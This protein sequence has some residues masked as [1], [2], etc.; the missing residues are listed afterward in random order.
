[1]PCTGIPKAPGSCSSRWAGS[2]SK[3]RAQSLFCCFASR[4]EGSGALR[5]L[6]SSVLPGSDGAFPAQTEKYC[7]GT[8]E[9]STISI[10]PS[11]GLCPSFSSLV[12][13]SQWL[14]CCQQGHCSSRAPHPSAAAGWVPAQAD[15]GLFVP[16]WESTGRELVQ[17]I[18]RCRTVP[19]SEFPG[20]A[21]SLQLNPTVMPRLRPW[22]AAAEESLCPGC[23][24]S[25][26]LCVASAISAPAP[27]GWVSS[28]SCSASA[29]SWLL[30]TIHSSMGHRESLRA[31][32]RFLLRASMELGCA[33]GACCKQMF[34]GTNPA[35]IMDT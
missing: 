12:L 31:C 33:W 28:S 4:K 35:C 2:G 9:R 29:K 30:S 11:P 23:R 10:R 15:D 21:F 13:H 20:L 16:L 19:C 17:I 26:Q 22:M 27:V 25:G 24:S 3:A 6:C 5:D 14:Y 18:S 7:L 1:M 34:A 32:V 8:G